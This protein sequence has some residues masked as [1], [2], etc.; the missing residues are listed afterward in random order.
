[1]ANTVQTC[2]SAQGE[3]PRNVLLRRTPTQT[4]TR[5][6]D[7][8]TVQELVS[9]GLPMTLSATS[10]GDFPHKRRWAT[11]MPSKPSETGKSISSRHETLGFVLK[12]DP[13]VP[14]WPTTMRMYFSAEGER[15]RF[16]R[17]LRSIPSSS[18]KFG[19]TTKCVSGSSSS[20]ECRL[21]D[22]EERMR[23]HRP[24]EHVCCRQ[25]SRRHVIRGVRGELTALIVQVRPAERE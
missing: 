20:D 18:C 2:F 6:S 7:S 15:E 5:H 12:C 10:N 16:F 17:V 8:L 23:L 9:L 13:R 14:P 21:F 25:G 24:Q 19:R 4:E 22:E 1:M 3:R 11:F